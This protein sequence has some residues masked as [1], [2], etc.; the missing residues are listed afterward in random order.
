MAKA[1]T[2][3]EI[4]DADQLTLDRV[5]SKAPSLIT[6]DDLDDLVVALRNQRSRFIAADA[7]KADKKEGIEDG[8]SNDSAE[9]AELLAE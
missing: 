7:K 5:L 3:K 6:D 1:P 8:S 4:A 2:E 9:D